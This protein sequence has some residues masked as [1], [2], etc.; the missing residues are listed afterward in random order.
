MS[1]RPLRPVPVLPVPVLPVPVL[2]LLALLALL[3]PLVAAPASARTVYYQIV[4]DASFNQVAI[5]QGYAACSDMIHSEFAQIGIKFI[6]DHTSA[7]TGSV[8]YNVSGSWSSPSWGSKNSVFLTSLDDFSGF[9]EQSRWHYRIG[10][11]AKRM[12]PYAGASYHTWKGGGRARVAVVSWVKPDSTINTTWAS[13]A[14]HE[15][16]HL[17]REDGYHHTDDETT[18]IRNCAMDVTDY[19]GT[20][21]ALHICPYCRDQVNRIM[22]GWTSLTGGAGPSSM[23]SGSKTGAVGPAQTWRWSE[24]YWGLRGIDAIAWQ[25]DAAGVNHNYVMGWHG[26]DAAEYRM[27]LGQS[28]SNNDLG[29]VG[30]AD[31]PGPVILNVYND[32]HYDETY[33]WDA[34]NN[35]NQT[36]WDVIWGYNGAVGAR[37]I[38]VE[39]ALDYYTGPGDG[40]RNLYLDG[41][42]IW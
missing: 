30:K 19:G 8:T 22:A 9:E 26:L 29:L 13:T 4:C 31:R 2:K 35:V 39:F 38:A 27:Q 7:K 28:G 14:M 36:K 33:R 10:F 12:S 3:T 5:N 23:G 21:Q 41:L 6:N 34:N 17:L 16:T 24:N 18:A 1:P 37:Q 15:I 42:G 32:G 40:D 11:T 25:V 20:T